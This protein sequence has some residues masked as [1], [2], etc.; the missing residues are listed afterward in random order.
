MG[1]FSVPMNA[2]Q[3]S[4]GVGWNIMVQSLKITMF[5]P[6]YVHQCLIQKSVELTWKIEAQSDQLT[7]KMSGAVEL[8]WLNSIAVN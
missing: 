1:S 7:W 3:R 8:N 4:H 2:D 5:T 6:P